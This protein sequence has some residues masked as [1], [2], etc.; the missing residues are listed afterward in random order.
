MRSELYQY[1]LIFAGIVA[2]IL[3]GAFLYREIYPEYKI[4]Q[5]DYVALEKFRSTYTGEPP[6]A[7]QIGV[8][9]IVMEREDKGPI[10]QV[11]VFCCGTCS[12][13][14]FLWKGGGDETVA[15][16][17]WTQ[18]PGQDKDKDQYRRHHHEAE[19]SI[20]LILPDLS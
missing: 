4:Y 7:F 20:T 14:R 1:T 17:W 2:T 12:P 6:P 10:R 13:R 15:G 11:R 3:F 5:E 19:K 18:A 16:R 8:K 9:Q